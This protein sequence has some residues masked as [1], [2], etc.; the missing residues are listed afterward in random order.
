MRHGQEIP[1]NDRNILPRTMAHA[2][3]K[4]Y[5]AA[6]WRAEKAGHRSNCQA[7]KSR[8][9]RCPYKA[10]WPDIRSVRLRSGAEL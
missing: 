9:N 5:G 7:R 1:V 4:L 10:E 3:A 2:N 6:S 8:M